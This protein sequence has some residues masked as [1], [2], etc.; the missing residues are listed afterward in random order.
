M[1]L[2]GA[3]ASLLKA[4]VSTKMIMRQVVLH[5]KIRGLDPIKSV[6]RAAKTKTSVGQGHK[7]KQNRIYQDRL[8]RQD[9]LKGGAIFS[10]S[11]AILNEIEICQK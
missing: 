10:F 8:R 6:V 3:L 11:A 9:R 4:V 2:E 1:V 5:R 7:Q